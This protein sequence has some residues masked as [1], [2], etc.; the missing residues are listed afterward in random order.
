[1]TRTFTAAVNIR[2]S[3]EDGKRIDELDQKGIS[4]KD[5]FLR[6]LDAYERDIEKKQK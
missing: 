4:Q 2:I 3:I 1:M 6:G 5:I